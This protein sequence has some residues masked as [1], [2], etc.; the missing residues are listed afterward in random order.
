MNRWAVA[1]LLLAAGLIAGVPSH[2]GEPE[3]AWRKAARERIEKIR[4][5]ELTLVVKDAS[6]APVENASVSVKMCRHAFGFGTAV[7]VG[8]LDGRRTGVTAEDVQQYKEHIA[9]FFNK[10]VIENSLKWPAWAEVGRRQSTLDSVKWLHDIGHQVRGHVLVWP[11][12]RRMAEEARVLK[13]QPGELARLIREHVAEE[14]TALRGQIAEWDVINEPYSNHDVMDLL[15]NK[16]MVEW[17]KEARKADPDVKL[18]INDFAIL[19]TRDTKH[20]DHYEETIRYLIDNGAP[21]DGIGLQGHFKS[22]LT[23]PE[24][25]LKM[26]DRFGA[27]GKT[28]QVTEFDIDITDEQLQADYTRD[29]MTAAFS[30]PS[31]GGFLMWGFW[32]KSH[33][34]PSGAMFRADWTQKPNAKVYEDLVFNQWWTEEVRET[35]AQGRCVVRGYLGDYDVEARSGEKVK[36]VRARLSREGAVVNLRLD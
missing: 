11:S 34:R 24:D 23:P 29:F 22:N 21:L 1:R 31:V 17:F 14:V 25:V 15:G 19:T 8:T 3:A 4:K 10:A 33:W 2:G 26:L 30:H 5:G 32:E 27:F 18:Y 20:Q 13:D 36:N 6:G 28:L 16:V 7:N 12:W 9:R 35:D